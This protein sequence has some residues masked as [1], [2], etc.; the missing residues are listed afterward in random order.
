MRENNSEESEV[1]DD[2]PRYGTVPA[3]AGLDFVQ[4]DEEPR[5]IE[6]DVDS[7]DTEEAERTLAGAEHAASLPEIAFRPLA[8][9]KLT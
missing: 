1:L 3:L 2:V 8:M 9:M 4:R 6:K 7:V 5:P